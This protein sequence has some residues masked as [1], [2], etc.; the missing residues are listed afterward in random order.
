MVSPVTRKAAGKIDIVLAESSAASKWF[1]LEIQAVVLF[2]QR[3][4]ERL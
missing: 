2:R 1:G 3:H 4:G